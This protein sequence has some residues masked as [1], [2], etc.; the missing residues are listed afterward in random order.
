MTALGALTQVV[1]A[2]ALGLPLE[3]PKCASTTL[4]QNIVMR[5]L[6]DTGVLRWVHSVIYGCHRGDHQGMRCS[7]FKVQSLGR[8][9]DVCIY[10]RR[11][12]HILYHYTCIHSAPSLVCIGNRMEYGATVV[13][14]ACSRLYNGIRFDGRDICRA[15]SYRNLLVK[16]EKERTSIS[17]HT[18]LRRQKTCT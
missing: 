10:H 2:R 1:W 15:I 17:W 11:L 9:A 7:D 13:H 6:T 4:L 12:S 8:M 3:R 5:P 18:Y 16:R 14:H